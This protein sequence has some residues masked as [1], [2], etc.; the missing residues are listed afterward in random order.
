MCVTLI[1]TVCPARAAIP[2]LSLNA[3]NAASITK[4]GER[5]TL[6]ILPAIADSP[7][8]RMFVRVRVEL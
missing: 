3:S 1:L 2:V 6:R 8:G 4:A 5:V 7:T